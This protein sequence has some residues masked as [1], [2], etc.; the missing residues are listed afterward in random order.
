MESHD[1]AEAKAILECS[2]KPPKSPKHVMYG[3]F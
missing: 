2:L 3:F 1:L